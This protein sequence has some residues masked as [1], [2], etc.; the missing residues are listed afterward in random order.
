M[1]IIEISETLEQFWSKV[2]VEQHEA[3]L[4]ELKLSDIILLGPVPAGEFIWW[5]R[6][7]KSVVVRPT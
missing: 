1:S 3:R 6:N 7:A 4:K 2:Q 5:L